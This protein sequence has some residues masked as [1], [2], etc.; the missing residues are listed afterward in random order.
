MLLKKTIES[1]FQVGGPRSVNEDK[2]VD[3]MDGGAGKKRSST[4]S[5]GGADS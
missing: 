3:V 4:D 2:I 1:E 5:V